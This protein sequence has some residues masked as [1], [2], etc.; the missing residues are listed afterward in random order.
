MEQCPADMQRNLTIAVYTYTNIANLGTTLLDQDLSYRSYYPCLLFKADKPTS[1]DD[2][3]QSLT[4]S[5]KSAAVPMLRQGRAALDDRSSVH[6]PPEETGQRQSDG[7]QT[8]CHRQAFR[9]SNLGLD[10][11]KKGACSNPTCTLFQ[12]VKEH[13]SLVGSEGVNRSLSKPGRCEACPHAEESTARVAVSSWLALSP[14]SSV[15][16]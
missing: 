4:L 9:I 13:C 12:F 16:P 14:P 6:I 8:F 10:P 11:S 15:F 2:E 5:G 7:L 1:S 3:L